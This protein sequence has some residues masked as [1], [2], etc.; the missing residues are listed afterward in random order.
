MRL[1][2]LQLLAAGLGTAGDAPAAARTNIL[3]INSEDNRP[4]PGCSGDPLAQTPH[5]DRLAAQGGRCRRA[6]KGAGWCIPRNPSPHE[7]RP[8]AAVRRLVAGRRWL[9]LASGLTPE[10][11]HRCGA[12]SAVRA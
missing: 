4:Y 9:R 1:K 5:L 2:L 6:L 8:A 12:G 3:R 7:T 11:W 10:W